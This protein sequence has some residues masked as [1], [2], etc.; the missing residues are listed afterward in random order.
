MSVGNLRAISMND[1]SD[2][3]LLTLAQAASLRR[4]D[5]SGL[6]KIVASTKRGTPGPQIQFFQIG[7]G[8]IKFRRK[9][10]ER[11]IEEHLIKPGQVQ[12]RKRRRHS[13]LTAYEE[14]MRD[15][16]QRALWSNRSYEIKRCPECYFENKV[17]GV[18][19]IVTCEKCGEMFC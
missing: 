1:D 5:A 3:R 18:P 16:V 19:E 14:M 10:I 11:F 15:P 6:P 8:R 12:Q 17:M 7:Q 4:M 13:N 2:G 9:W